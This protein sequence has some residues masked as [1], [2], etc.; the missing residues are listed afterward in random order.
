MQ[1][2][3]EKRTKYPGRSRKK[4]KNP[5]RSRKFGRKSRVDIFPKIDLLNIEGVQ[6]FSGIAQYSAFN[7][8]TSKERYI[9][10]SHV[11]IFRIYF[12]GQN[13]RISVGKKYVT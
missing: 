3:S 6:F 10:S 5:G 2:G 7:S 13:F 9:K 11:S 12:I 1:E 8:N 4:E